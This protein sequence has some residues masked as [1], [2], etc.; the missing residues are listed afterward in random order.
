MSSG[1]G[2]TGFPGHLPHPGFGWYG[3]HM[4]ELSRK[5]IRLDDRW[6]TSLA[7]LAEH[8]EYVGYKDEEGV[9]TLVPADY[10]HAPV[11]AQL[12]QPVGS[13]VR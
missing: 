1:C 11:V 8:K 12:K 7:G 9:I 5:S 4:K 3:A 2:Y 6:R 10:V 13:G